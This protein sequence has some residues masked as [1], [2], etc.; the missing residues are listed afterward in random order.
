M[1]AGAQ[2]AYVRYVQDTAKRSP[3]LWWRWVRIGM[4][5]G[6]AVLAVAFAFPAIGQGQIF[7]GVMAVLFAALALAWALMIPWSIRRQ[8]ERMGRLWAELEERCA[9]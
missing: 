3:L 2:L 7:D 6:Y 8:G 4:P 9:N 1:L 5:V